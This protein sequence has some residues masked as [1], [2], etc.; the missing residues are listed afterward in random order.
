MNVRELTNKI[1]ATEDYMTAFNI[2][3]NYAFFNT[4]CYFYETGSFAT[5]EKVEGWGTYCCIRIPHNQELLDALYEKELITNGYMVRN[6]E[7]IDENTFYIIVYEMLDDIEG[8]PLAVIKGDTNWIPNSVSMI[9]IE[10]YN[11]IRNIFL[12]ISK[13]KYTTDVDYYYQYTNITDI[14]KLCED[15][16]FEEQIEPYRMYK[17]EIQNG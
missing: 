2:L 12:F 3:K 11:K 9:K 14:L 16:N 15:E 10:V 1:K 6:T 17:K 13:Y 5:L 8:Y 7:T 4:F